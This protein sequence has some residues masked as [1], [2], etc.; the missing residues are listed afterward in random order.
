MQPLFQR[1]TF[2]GLWALSC[3]QL[4]VRCS[5]RDRQRVANADRRNPGPFG[6]S[7]CPHT[8]I[9]RT[10]VGTFPTTSGQPKA[11]NFTLALGGGE[12]LVCG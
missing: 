4:H 6:I 3:L 5:T 11:V 12:P 2:Q 1:F 8:G 9:H 10:G 7:R